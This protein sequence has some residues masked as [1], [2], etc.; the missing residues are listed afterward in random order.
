MQNA[1]NKLT[2]RGSAQNSMTTFDCPSI[3]TWR[4]FTCVYTWGGSVIMWVDGGNRKSASNVYASNSPGVKL[5]LATNLV[6]SGD[7][8]RIHNGATSE[9]HAQADYKTQTDA[10]FLVYGTVEN[11]GG[12][13]LLIFV[14]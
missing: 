9:A 13:G 10:N 11:Q 12:V 2:F 5:S 14:R 1:A 8:F 3:T 7:E 6:G 4:Y